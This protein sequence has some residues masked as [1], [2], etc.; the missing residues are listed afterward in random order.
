MLWGDTVSSLNH[1]CVWSEDAKA[2]IPITA[3]AA[4]RIY[5]FT[6]SGSEKKFICDLCGHYATFTRAGKKTRHFRH[7]SPEDEL[8]CPEYRYGTSYIPTYSFREDHPLPIRL[9]LSGAVPHLEVGMLYIPENILNA[10]PEKTVTI[11]TSQGQPFEYSFERLNPETTTYLNVGTEPSKQY[12]IIAP[13]ALYAIWPKQFEGIPSTGCV[14]D[15]ASG[16]KLPIDSDVTVDTK[17]YLLTNKWIWNGYQ[18]IEL[19]Q[20]CDLGNRNIYEVKALKCSIEAARFFLDYGYRLTENPLSI[21]PLW[22]THRE[23]SLIIK[24]DSKEVVLSVSGRR[25]SEC[26]L[27]PRDAMNVI[28]TSDTSRAVILDCNRR[29]QYFSIY[30]KGH[31]NVIQYLYLWRYSFKSPNATP[32]AEVLDQNEQDVEPGVHDSLPKDGTL[33]VTPVFDGKVVCKR[34]GITVDQR[35]LPAETR[36]VVDGITFSTEVLIYQGL[37]VIWS[38]VFQ[39]KSRNAGSDDEALYSKLQGFH[40]EPV[41]VYHELGA[42]AGRLRGYPKVRA[43]IY[44]TVRKGSADRKAIQYLKH[45]VVNNTVH[46]E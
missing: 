15:G 39:R 38:A 40:G 30:P 28:P 34:A 17:Y 20:L 14:F 45:Y 22:P 37:D 42:L 29:D 13:S 44:S 24:H 41:P 46:K 6:V 18:D 33:Y 31:S 19:K 36:S 32:S 21:V 27:Q 9:V 12:R 11:V 25:I 35:Q 5:P 4:A 3:Q 7:F 16:R 23:D 2:W 43:W 8:N 10:Q 1:V 26:R